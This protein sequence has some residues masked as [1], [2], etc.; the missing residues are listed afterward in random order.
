MQ[1][2]SVEMKKSRQIEGLI[3]QLWGTISMGRPKL[4]KLI[5]SQERL[6]RVVEMM[7]I[8]I[9][10]PL[11]MK[12][13]VVLE[14]HTNSNNEWLMFQAADR[15]QE[16]IKDL[17]SNTVFSRKV[18]IRQTKMISMMTTNS[19]KPHS[20]FLNSQSRMWL[21]ENLLVA[22]L[23][24]KAISRTILK[25]VWGWVWATAKAQVTT[26]KMNQAVLMWFTMSTQDSSLN[27][28]TRKN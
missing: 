4:L 12:V 13:R 5:L 23:L 19:T 15:C 1:C 24:V 27:S 6:T 11:P 21:C 26:L 18:F 22:V 14:N 20:N 25:R 10:I 17:S 3:L 28:G 9:G 2:Q 16:P 8:F 7:G